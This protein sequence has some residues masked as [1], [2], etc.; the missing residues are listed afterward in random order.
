MACKATRDKNGTQF[1]IPESKPGKTAGGHVFPGS[2]ELQVWWARRFKDR[3]NETLMIRQ[4]NSNK[5][6]DL[7]ELTLAQAYDLH[8][9]L[10]C[11]IMDS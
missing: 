9:A 6:V 1:L 4:E 5:K 7:I 2:A 3:N 10:G 11:A 8:H